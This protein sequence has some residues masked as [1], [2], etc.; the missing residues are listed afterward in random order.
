[1]RLPALLLAAT[2]FA[3]CSSS[4]DG[5][6]AEVDALTDRDETLASGEF[7][8][9]YTVRAAAGQWI[10]VDVLS[11]AFSPYLILRSPAGEQTDDPGAGPGDRSALLFQ[12]LEDGSYEISVTS[13][14]AGETGAYALVYEVS[15]DAPAQGAAG[16]PSPGLPPGHPALPGA[17]PGLS[18]SP[19]GPAL[20]PGTPFTEEELGEG[21]QI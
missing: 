2:A 6:V 17:A 8:D 12:A 5:L 3:A 19:G 9:V 21:V 13:V 15:D 18:P 16:A 11:S 10:K 4:P 20:R 7:R 14:A 1:M